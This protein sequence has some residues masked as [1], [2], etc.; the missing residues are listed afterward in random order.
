MRFNWWGK[1]PGLGRMRILRGVGLGL[2]GA[3]L[4]GCPGSNPPPAPASQKVVIRGSNTIGE[5]LAPRLIAEF[6]KANPAVMFDLETK[7]TG[8]GLAAVRSGLCDI[9]GASRIPIREELEENQARGVQL[10]EYIIG[11]YSVAVVVNAGNPLADLGRGQVRDIFTGAVRNWK[12]VG[13]ADAPVRLYARDPISGTHLGF[14]ELAMEDK[15]YASG[16]NLF[17]NYADIAQAVAKDPGGIGYVSF[18]LANGTGVKAVSIGGVQP[19]AAAVNS[20]KYP[21]ARVLRFYTNKAAE[22]APTVAFL[23]FV[24]SPPGQKVLAEAGFVPRP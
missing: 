11:A 15:S 7:A 13:G 16:L 22:S 21:Y 10:N 18:D 4:A 2:I 9:A 1:S 14:R 12:E 8:Y 20:G 6:K 3:V 24:L 19:T 17:T 5:E 23:Q